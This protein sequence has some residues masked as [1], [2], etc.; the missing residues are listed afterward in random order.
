MD[1]TA[2]PLM[3]RSMCQRQ[4]ICRP[5]AFS[6]RLLSALIGKDSDL[7]SDRIEHCLRLK[8]SDQFH[9]QVLR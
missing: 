7:R 8:K 4:Q 2:D 3:P 1:Y 5:V 9:D 6:I